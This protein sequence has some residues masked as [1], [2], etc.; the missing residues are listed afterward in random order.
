V[1]SL[2]GAVAFLPFLRGAV[3]GASLYFRD[4]ALYFF[5]LRR[6]GLDG[7]RSGELRFWNPYL[8]EGVPLSLPAV[9]YPVDLL[10]L[11][12]ADEAG[13][14]LVLALHVPLAAVG[15]YALARGLLEAP[16]SAAA[17]GALVYALGGF[18]LSTVNLYVYLEAAAWAPL[19]VLAL[20]RAMTS[21]SARTVAGAALAVGVALTTTGVE[22]V[23]QAVAVGL[24]LGRRPARDR[25]ADTGACSGP[26]PPAAGRCGP[27]G[28]RPVRALGGAGAAL[29]LGSLLAAPVLVLL[30]SQVGGS[31]RSQGFET[32]VVL[33]HSV[34]PFTLVQV[35]VAGLYGNLANLAGEWWGQ[36]FFP[37]G[38]PYILSLYLGPAALALAGVGATARHALRWRLVLLG[39]AGLVLCVGRWAGLAAAVDALPVLSAFRYPVKAF[40]A[41]HLALALLVALGLSRLAS[42][43]SRWWARLATGAGTLGGLLTLAPLLPHVAPA[44]VDAFAAAFF[45]PGFDPRT[46]T[47]LLHRVLVDA[48]TGGAVALAVAAVAG[49]A[50]RRTLPSSRAA[51]L[52]VAMVAADLLRAGSGLNPMVDGGFFRPSPELAAELGFLREGRVFT[53]SFDESRGYR[54]ARA[55]R[56]AAHETWTFQVALETLTPAFNVPL[57][58]SSALSPDLTMLVPEDRVLSPADATCHDLEAI[59]PRLRR[60]GVHAIVSVDPLDHPALEPRGILSPGRLAP[61]RVHLYRLRAPL[62]LVRVASGVVPAEDGAEGARRATAPGFRKAGGVAREGSAPGRVVGRRAGTDRLEIEVRADAPA[63]LVVRDGWASGWRAWVDGAPTPVRRADGRHRGVAVPAGASTVVMR[64]RPPHLVPSLVTSAVALVVLV[65]L[66]RRRRPGPT[67]GRPPTG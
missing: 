27:R 46:R 48:A 9:G 1:A 33:A 53:C 24:V 61:L 57:R 39:L 42:A 32:D 40:F 67:A 37:R 50:H 64:Y 29:T 49:L 62:P 23:A 56:G 28:G 13:I 4:L 45:P 15:F 47:V 30:A 11:L 51:L 14:S 65:G 34:H 31:A 12:R 17:G 6:L 36:N 7:L 60:A 2:V 26:G 66:L 55:A 20:S 38:F 52:V 59:L 21:G 54:E 16:A 25:V 44:S 5:P 63:T 35:V 41:V 43:E 18:V 58:V 22:I 19:V 8:H 10:Q 3:S